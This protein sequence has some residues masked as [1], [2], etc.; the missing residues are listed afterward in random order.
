MHPACQY[1]YPPLTVPDQAQPPFIQGNLGTASRHLHIGPLTEIGF[2]HCAA[3]PAPVMWYLKPSAVSYL[4]EMTDSDLNKSRLKS[5][6]DRLRDSIEVFRICA[7]E[8]CP[9]AAAN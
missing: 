5:P 8:G 3:P 1:V 4:E 6:L 2:Q 9:R 7:N